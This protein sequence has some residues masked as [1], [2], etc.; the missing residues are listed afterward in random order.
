MF[1]YE[2]VH[3]FIQFHCISSS[4][5]SVV[6]YCPPGPSA[7]LWVY[8]CRDCPRKCYEGYSQV[9]IIG[10]YV[11]WSEIICLALR[12]GVTVQMSTAAV[13]LDLQNIELI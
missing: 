12:S 2:A 9:F 7:G 10:L 5:P 11:S 4:V 13:T 3:L 1:R 6:L 8:T